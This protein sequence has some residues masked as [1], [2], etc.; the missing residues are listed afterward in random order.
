MILL[1][2]RQTSEPPARPCPD[3]RPRRATAT[4]HAV[5][6]SP[7]PGRAGTGRNK[8][9]SA[10]QPWGRRPGHRCP[11]C[12]RPIPTGTT[13]VAAVGTP[14]RRGPMWW[15]H[16]RGSGCPRHPWIRGRGERPSATASHTRALPGADY[17][18]RRRG[19]RGVGRVAGGSRGWPHVLPARGATREGEGWLGPSCSAARCDDAGCMSSALHSAWVGCVVLL[20]FRDVL[21][22]HAK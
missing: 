11:L 6:W 14:R 16:L 18:R 5:R 4:P 2:L 17:L 13:T 3:H 22:Y 20:F 9:R 10:T 7:D 12:I 21:R 19:G 8:G 15:P 1:D